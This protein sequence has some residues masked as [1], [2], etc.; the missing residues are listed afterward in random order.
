MIYVGL[1]FSPSYDL[2]PTPPTPPLPSASCFSFSVLL[3]DA[4]EM[5]RWARRSYRAG[6][7]WSFIIHSIF[8]GTYAQL[9][10][11]NTYTEPYCNILG[12]FLGQKALIFLEEG[13]GWGIF[14]KTDCFYFYTV[15]SIRRYRSFLNVIKYYC[16]RINRKKSNVSFIVISVNCTSIL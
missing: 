7:A 2:A 10:S 6:K 1:A 4:G 3:F 14:L 8:S 9:T 16:T 15:L 12:V 13:E 11:A 5:R